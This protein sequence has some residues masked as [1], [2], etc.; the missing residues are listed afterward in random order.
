M[1]NLKIGTIRITVV[2]VL[3]LDGGLIGDFTSFA[4][5]FQLY[6]H[7]GLVKL[8]GLLQWNSVCD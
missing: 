5:V 6:Q 4:I 8:K 2:T 7:D 3:K 1:K